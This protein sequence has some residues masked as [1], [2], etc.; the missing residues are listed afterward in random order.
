M[1]SKTCLNG[2]LYL[3]DNLYIEDTFLD[4]KI[5]LSCINEPAIK[6]QLSIK[7]TFLQSFG[8]C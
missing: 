8:V 6:E 3:K 4:P 1:Y 7:D 2:H 5:S